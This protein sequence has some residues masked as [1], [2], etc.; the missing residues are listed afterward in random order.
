MG[1]AII[2]GSGKTPPPNSVEIEV[3]AAEDIKAGEFVGMELQTP[4]T[5]DYADFTAFTF[6]Q[7]SDV[8]NFQSNVDVDGI[9]LY[10][11]TATSSSMT[12]CLIQIFDDGTI[13]QGTSVVISGSSY[14]VQV[15]RFDNYILVITKK[16][17]Y[18]YQMQGLELTYISTTNIGTVY[19]GLINSTG[20]F[21]TKNN[22]F[23][24]SKRIS[25]SN[26]HTLFYR[27]SNGAITLLH[28]VSMPSA[29]THVNGLCSIKKSSGYKIRA[30][31]V[32]GYNNKSYLRIFDC[33]SSFQNW[34]LQSEQTA[35]PNYISSNVIL[36][37]LIYGGND[38]GGFYAFQIQDDDSVVRIG[39]ANLDS[40]EDPTLSSEIQALLPAEIG[41]AICNTKSS[42][43]SQM[44]TTSFFSKENTSKENTVEYPTNEI[45][46]PDS[47]STDCIFFFTSALKGILISG[48][49]YKNVDICKAKKTG[50]ELTGIAKT[51]ALQG[52]KLKIWM[53]KGPAISYLLQDNMDK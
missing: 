9:Y 15:F 17:M 12:I 33:D 32:D 30:I 53:S 46:P 5:D 4:T 14:A 27:F 48:T 24:I 10:G 39:F 19:N 43:M 22:I 21:D 25:S 47:A 2:M 6:S 44:F 20:V 29:S 34:T 42:S 13:E 36:D 7:L 37:N 18:L 8:Y 38:N 31:Y 50:V 41:F 49:Q 16:G 52:N 51:S 26:L 35:I 11:A 23:T 28:D 40:I 45:V 3:T 1:N